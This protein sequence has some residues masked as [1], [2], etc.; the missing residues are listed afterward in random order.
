MASNKNHNVYIIALPT[1]RS[2]RRLS[3]VFTIRAVPYAS[4]HRCYDGDVTCYDSALPNCGM[5]QATATLTAMCYRG[6]RL[7]DADSN[8][9]QP[10]VTLFARLN[11][12]PGPVFITNHI[13]KGQVEEGQS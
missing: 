8:N 5:S 3:L 13:T 1:P 11:P 4:V 7:T 12:T 9:K 6:L 2:T 10:D